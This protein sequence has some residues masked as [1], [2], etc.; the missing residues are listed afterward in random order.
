MSDAIRPGDGARPSPGVL[1]GG[2]GTFGR[3]YKTHWVRLVKEL[4]LL[5]ISEMEST[6]RRGG[7]VTTLRLLRSF[8]IG[9]AKSQKLV[10][11]K[12]NLAETSAA[13]Y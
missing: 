10:P 9:S 1:A 7:S 13:D 3:A 8:R 12:L 5:G 4:T 6:L 11:T 2:V